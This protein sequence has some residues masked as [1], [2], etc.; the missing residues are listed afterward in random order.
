MKF[1]R[2]DWQGRRRNRLDL[3]ADPDPSVHLW[4]IIRN[5]SPLVNISCFKSWE[6]R[7]WHAPI[8]QMAAPFRRSFETSA[9]FWS[10]LEYL[11][12]T[13]AVIV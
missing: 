10:V 12:N 7:G 13:K 2:S 9:R 3:G 4:I 5:S 11:L 8:R 1:C 6:W